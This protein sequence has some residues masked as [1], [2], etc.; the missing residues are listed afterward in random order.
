LDTRTGLRYVAVDVAPNPS[1][2]PRSGTVTI[3][4]TRTFTVN[5]SGGIAV[6]FA[7]FDPARTSDP[8]TECVVQS[9][10]GQPTTCV[11]KSTSF[12]YDSAPIVSYAW[13]LSYT[14]NVVRIFTKTGPDPELTFTQACGQ[15][16]PTDDYH[17]FA[18]LTVTDSHGNTATASAG[19]FGQPDL[20][21]L[22][23]SCTS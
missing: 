9:S 17:L 15:P 13:E 22:P 1:P 10:T 2:T 5:Q 23:L 7:L 6:S 16:G 18:K 21:I 8:T 12:T 11:L 19:I 14:Y 4:E 3:A 20:Q